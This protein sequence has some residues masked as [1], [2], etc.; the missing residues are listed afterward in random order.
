M[1]KESVIGKHKQKE[2][3]AELREKLFNAME[4]LINEIDFND[5]EKTIVDRY[6]EKVALYGLRSEEN[7]SACCKTLTLMQNFLIIKELKEI[8]NKLDNK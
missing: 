3:Q 2:E 6:A 1:N 7:Y 8:N 5:D 4:K